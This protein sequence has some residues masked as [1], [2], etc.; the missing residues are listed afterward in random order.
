MRCHERVTPGIHHVTAHNRLRA[1]NNH[2]RAHL[3]VTPEFSLANSF[4]YFD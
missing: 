2:F 1:T 3:V 4:D